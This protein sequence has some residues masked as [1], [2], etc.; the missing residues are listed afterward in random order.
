[1]PAPAGNIEAPEN[2]PLND[3]DVMIPALA[4]C[5]QPTITLASVPKTNPAFGRTR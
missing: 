5:I 4:D 1:M 3:D 2:V